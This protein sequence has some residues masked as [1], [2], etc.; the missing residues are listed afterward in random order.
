MSY[1]ESLKEI[2]NSIKP[3]MSYCIFAPDLDADKWEAVLNKF[4][5]Q[6]EPISVLCIG[7]A[8]LKGILS[9]LSAKSFLLTNEKLYMEKIE[10]GMK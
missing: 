3:E 9:V 6:E 4:A 7:E 5:P 8:S 2:Y 10:D 1:L